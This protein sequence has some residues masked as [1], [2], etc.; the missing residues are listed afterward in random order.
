M[1]QKYDTQEKKNL[2]AAGMDTL[3]LQLR[4]PEPAGWVAREKCET[5]V[6]EGHRAVM[7]LP[8]SRLSF[9]DDAS[10]KGTPAKVSVADQ[11]V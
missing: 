6:P 4:A 5:V 1:T 10:I 7:Y 9:A 3:F 8:V 2:L 11:P